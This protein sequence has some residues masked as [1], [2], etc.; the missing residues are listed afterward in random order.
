MEKINY[1]DEEICKECGG[2]CCKAMPGSCL[3]EDFEEPIFES[4]RDAL[5]TGKYAVDWW[6]GDPTD[7]DELDRACYI[8]P[9]T[10]GVEKIYDP[11][12]G[13]ECIFFTEGKGCELQPDERPANCRLLEPRK[14]GN[15][16][17][18]ET[19]NK[20]DIAIAWIPHQ[21]TIHKAVQNIQN[22]PIKKKV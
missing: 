9:R 8:R 17:L 10:K 12:W 5:A 22:K 21:D 18:H 15:C 2:D 4:I 1:L 6:E 13:G 14:V 19:Y 3:P 7:N 11:S 20:R 16:V